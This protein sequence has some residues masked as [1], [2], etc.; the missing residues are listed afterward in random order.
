MASCLRGEL[1]C[2]TFAA[3][4][5]QSLSTNRYI[6]NAVFYPDP[7]N[8]ERIIFEISANAFLWRMV[9]SLTGSLI[10]FEKSGRDAAYFRQVL[11]S[12]DRKMAGPT[13]PAE[14]LFLWSV[15]FDGVRRHV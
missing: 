12:H 2:A 14:G 4:G 7:A 13:A 10:F 5:D 6:D 11:E 8:G 15:S 9:R 1:D 3:A